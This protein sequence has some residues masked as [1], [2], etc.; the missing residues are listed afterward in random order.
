MRLFN[1]GDNLPNVISAATR[2][3]G[4]VTT[5]PKRLPV[6][7]AARIAGASPLSNQTRVLQE[8]TALLDFPIPSP[9]SND[10]VLSGADHTQELEKKSIAELD[11]T[12]KSVLIGRLVASWI[13]ISGVS[14]AAK[15]ADVSTDWPRLS[16]KLGGS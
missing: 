12:L 6:K 13:S 11:P 15:N 4:N 1:H 10:S 7:L 5:I 8:W 9:L 16:F 2:S 14:A 3:R